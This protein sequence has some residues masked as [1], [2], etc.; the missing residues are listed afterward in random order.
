LASPY[1]IGIDENGLGSRLGPLVVTAVLA[2]ADAQGAEV[3]AKRLPRS[4]RAS[5]DD[6]KRLM[7]H[8]DVKLGEAW[9]RELAAPDAANPAEL[10]ERL[11]L[12]GS[13][14]LRRRCPER[15][16]AQCWSAGHD[17]FEASLTLKRQVARHR[18]LLAA[19]GVTLLAV[20]T[21]VICTD[22]LNRARRTG[23]N[24][25]HMDLHAMEALFLAL[26]K[27]AEQDVTCVC[28]K[29]GGINEYSRFFGPL[30][31]WLH[32]VLGEGQAKSEYRFPGVGEIAFVRDADASDP[33]VMLAS[34]VGKY[35]RELFMTRIAKH[36]PAPADA[37]RPSGYHDP[38]TAA[39]VDRTALVRKRQQLPDPCFERERDA[40]DLA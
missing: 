39:F 12:E 36:Y 8:T 11:S 27:T 4:I 38:V 2:R 9:A 33:L 15:A 1:R 37:P 6:S 18:G 3:L 17:V 34:L 16:E 31:G 20:K 25:F 30:G 5:L 19:R 24:R 13:P 40:L 28:G 26:R 32:N 35:V 14:A 29:V 23:K 10:F 7:S 22:S 21:S